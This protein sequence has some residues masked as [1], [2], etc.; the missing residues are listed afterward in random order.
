MGTYAHMFWKC[1]KIQKYWTDVK[2]EVSTLL[3]YNLELS[4]FHCVLAAKV[5]NARDKHNAKLTEILLYVAR[6]T[7]LKFWISSDCPTIEDWYTEVL[8]I[9]P[10]ERLTYF[11]HDN[12]DG[13]LDVWRPV[14][15]K[16]T[17]HDHII[18]Y[19]VPV[20]VWIVL[21]ME[22]QYFNGSSGDDT[23]M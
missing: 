21:K 2:N 12:N 16:L 23:C 6:K 11:L 7:I 1:V 18:A 15:H 17:L 22:L 20:I 14:L 5:D 8:R 10:L 9:L 4:P 19:N 3:G 13:F